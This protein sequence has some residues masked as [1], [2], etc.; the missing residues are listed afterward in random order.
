MAAALLGAQAGCLS[1]RATDD[2]A[3]ESVAGDEMDGMGPDD[4]TIADLEEAC[5]AE[6]MRTA[7]IERSVD[8][9]EENGRCAIPGQEG[10]VCGCQWVEEISFGPDVDECE[11]VAR[12]TYCRANVSRV[13]PGNGCLPGTFIDDCPFA[14]LGYQ[15]S[16]EEHLSAI[17][18][19]ADGGCNSPG[20]GTPYV[21]CPNEPD[22]P[23][24]QCLTAEAENIC[25]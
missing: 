8:F 15:T 23:I 24:C 19:V 22:S 10:R 9:R 17:G 5:A 21:A 20:T 4:L 2:G 18:V 16:T 6:D 7:C 14:F 25:M 1:A 13:G 12:E 11:V 3:A